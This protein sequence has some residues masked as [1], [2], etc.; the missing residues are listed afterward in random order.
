MKA[1]HFYFLLS[2]LCLFLTFLCTYYTRDSSSSFPYF[3][4]PLYTG[5]SQTKHCARYVILPSLRLTRN[6][7][8]VHEHSPI[9]KHINFGNCIGRVIESLACSHL[10]GTASSSSSS[11]MSIKMC[12]NRS[13]LSFFCKECSRLILIPSFLSRVYFQLAILFTP[14]PSARALSIQNPCQDED[15]LSL[16][17]L[18][19]QSLAVQQRGLLPS[20]RPSLPK[21]HSS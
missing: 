21:D 7:V 12:M 3:Y 10:I 20:L 6:E 1:I 13:T 5:R 4:V 9:L 15:P 19:K 16:R 8:I 14:P 18:Q 11:F 17:Y 2:L